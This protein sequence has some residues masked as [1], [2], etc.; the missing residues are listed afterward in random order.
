MTY[1]KFISFNI[2]WWFAWSLLFVYWWYF[3]WSIPTIQKNFS[4]VIILIIFVSL[5][6]MIFEW[7]KHKIQSKKK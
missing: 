5:C 1:K 7:I 2:V 4:L 6:P 3:F